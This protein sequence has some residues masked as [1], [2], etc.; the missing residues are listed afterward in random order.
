MLDPEA[1]LA[2]R[3]ETEQSYTERDSWIYALGL[4][5]GGD[6][7]D[8]AYVAAP[9]PRALPTMALVLAQGPS[10]IADPRAG[11]DFA[12][13]VHGAQSLTM[14]RPLPAAATVY[15]RAS[16][17]GLVDKGE[18]RGAIVSTTRELYDKGSGEHLAT[19]VQEA[20]CRGDG[21]FGGNAGAPV[22]ESPLPQR[23]ADFVVALPTSPRAALIY[24]LSGDLNPLHWNPERATSVGFARPILHGLAAF[25]MVGAALLRQCC[26]EDAVRFRTIRAQFSAPVTPGETIELSGW[27]EDGAVLFEG[28]VPGRDR[29]V[30]AG[31]RFTADGLDQ[32]MIND[33]EG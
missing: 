10:L 16:V 30:L 31:G 20:F 9:D 13:V 11:I 2:L 21:G 15:S 5:L 1:L 8:L 24:R 18:G 27:H 12:K 6:P 23:A 14:H 33:G 3:T 25:G 19:S 32:H 7:G 28:R 26:A 4:G 29:P 17:T 22:Q